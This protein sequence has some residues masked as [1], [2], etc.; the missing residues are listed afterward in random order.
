M[1]FHAGAEV[2][3]VT[4]KASRFNSFNPQRTL[5]RLY[6]P[7]GLSRPQNRINSRMI[8]VASHSRALKR[9]LPH[10][11]ILNPGGAS[12][13]FEAEMELTVIVSHFSVPLTVAF[14]PAYLSI[15]GLSPFN[16]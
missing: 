3:F 5:L 11:S 6:R 9:K 14:S 16:V 1:V 8:K 12:Y 10:S 2:D 4:V 15:A 13:F 7:G